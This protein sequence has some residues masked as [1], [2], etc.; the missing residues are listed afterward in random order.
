MVGDFNDDGHADLAITSGYDNTV[1]VLEGNGKGLFTPFIGSPIQVGNYPEAIKTGDFNGDGIQ[2]F[3]VA[4]AN[5][6]TIS[7]LLGNGDG[8]FTA[9]S[10]S[11]F[12]AGIGNFPFFIAVADF[13]NDGNLDLAVVNGR[14]NSVSFLEGEWRWNIRTVRRLSVHF[15]QL[16]P[17]PAQLWRRISIGMARLILR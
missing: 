17:V 4:N 2:D 7:I 10:G 16:V 12:N 6:N 14:D 5:D 15:P 9:A 8:T 1:T 3:A 11:P 13:N